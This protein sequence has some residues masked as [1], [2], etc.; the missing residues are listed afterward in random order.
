MNGKT[1]ASQGWFEHNFLFVNHLHLEPVL[2]INWLQYQ[3][4]VISGVK[5]EVILITGFFVA[6]NPKTACPQVE[7]YPLKRV[8]IP[9]RPTNKLVVGLPWYSKKVE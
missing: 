4:P 2:G 1:K 7:F 3:S 6:V 5:Y 8:C 9:L